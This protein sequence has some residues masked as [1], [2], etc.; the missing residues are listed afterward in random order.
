M[1]HHAAA[2]Q[3]GAL[4]AFFPAYHR[5]M[6]QGWEH[7]HVTH[8]NGEN[9][10]H[11]QQA[12]AQRAPA[13]DDDSDTLKSRA[14]IY[15]A[16]CKQLAPEPYHLPQRALDYV[17]VKGMRLPVVSV[18]TVRHDGTTGK[19]AQAEGIRLRITSEKWWYRRLRVQQGQQQELQAIRLGL[20]NAEKQAYVSDYGLSRVLAHQAKSLEWLD[21]MELID[22][23]TGEVLPLK[24]AADAGVS[25][26]VNRRN[27]MMLRIADGERYF[28]LNGYV[29]LF[30]T[31]T[32]PSKFHKFTKTGTHTRIDRMG[33][34]R[35][36]GG[37]VIA[38][39]KYQETIDGNTNTPKLAHAWLS[40]SWARFRAA[41]HHRGINAPYM[42]VTEPHAD[43]TEHQHAIVFVQP[44]HLKTYTRLLWKY[45]LREDGDEPG[46]TRHRVQIVKF[47]MSKGSAA[48]YIA[49][50]I[51][52]N[53]QTL[54]IEGDDTK[55]HETG[56]ESID[57]ATRVHAWR[58]RWVVR[59]FQFSQQF[60]KVSLWRELRRLKAESQPD[61]PLLDVARFAAD[62]GDYY[63]FLKITKQHPDT[64]AFL[65]EDNAKPNRYGEITERVRGITHDAGA[66][67]TRTH[68]WEL[69]QRAPDIDEATTTDESDSDFLIPALRA[70]SD[71]WSTVNNCRQ[72]ALEA[73]SGDVYRLVR[74]K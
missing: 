6:V 48:G 37:K 29:A 46:A 25:N 31:L 5:D 32:T 47:D 67:V 39:P 56:M 17:A 43:G 12:I 62:T 49:K 54:G 20:V 71:P 66:T 42:R 23:Q 69:H 58:S 50:Y 33:V 30:L 63:G 4:A 73:A 55:D 10:L 35:T 38:N 16:K 13:T 40:K 45:W 74:G 9:Y 60:G 53:I 52:K 22:T 18:N 59:A 64:F 51:A 65:L 3:S 21:S 72:D 57:S 34:K 24:Q 11:Q 26:P 61:A 19:K 36:I 8:N 70:V 27:E 44:A 14:I 41:I 2:L 1:N 68:D 28:H 7:H 15:A